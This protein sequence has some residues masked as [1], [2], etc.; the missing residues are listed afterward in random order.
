M[1]P[2]M[3]TVMWANE[4]STGSAAGRQGTAGTAGTAAGAREAGGQG[5]AAALGN[6]TSGAHAA[7]PFHRSCHNSPPPR[8]VSRQNPCPQPT[9]RP[10]RTRGRP[11]LRL[12]AYALPELLLRQS[13]G[14]RLP[15]V[16]SQR[17]L[18]VD[19]RHGCRGGGGGGGGG[20]QGRGRTRGDGQPAA[21][22][23][24]AAAARR[25]GCGSAEA[26]VGPLDE[27]CGP[28]HARFEEMGRFFS[29]DE[30]SACSGG[31]SRVPTKAARTAS[32]AQRWNPTI[33]T[34]QAPYNSHTPTAYTHATHLPAARR[35]GA[36]A[37]YAH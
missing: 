17:F 18:G 31:T 9:A 4:A 14:P 25:R 33:K 27:L 20:R 8:A 16:V 11:L 10:A 32:L 37:T 15:L 30:T 24:A 12:A 21:V 6:D 26:A 7:G 2:C 23:M 19:A 29:Q 36:R 28:G 22:V 5:S 13:A 34:Q 3:I 1:L 35:P